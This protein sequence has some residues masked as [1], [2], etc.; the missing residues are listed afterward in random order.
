MLAI[1]IAKMD[2]GE[3]LY[4][5]R[6]LLCANENRMTQHTCTAKICGAKYYLIS[7]L[8]VSFDFWM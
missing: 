1:C 6:I 5:V 8:T 4:N 2:I 3:N 7:L